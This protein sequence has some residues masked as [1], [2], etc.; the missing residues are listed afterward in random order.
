MLL[1]SWSED[2]PWFNLLS[3][4]SRASFSHSQFSALLSQPAVLSAYPAQMLVAA[5]SKHQDPR[6]VRTVSLDWRDSWRSVRKRAKKQT[7]FSLPYR[8][9]NERWWRCHQA[10]TKCPSRARSNV[11][12]R[13]HS[14]STWAFRPSSRRTPCNCLAAS[15]PI[16][17]HLSSASRNLRSRSYLR[18]LW[19]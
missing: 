14:Y 11:L 5:W 6:L 13:C 7:S 17:S 19:A 8:V 9:E 12:L 18:C 2:H 16:L 1:N 15:L 4:L 10:R 3:S